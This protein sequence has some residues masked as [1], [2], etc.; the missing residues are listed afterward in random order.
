MTDIT[1][2]CLTDHSNYSNKKLRTCSLRVLMYEFKANIFKSPLLGTDVS[3]FV[4]VF[5]SCSSVGVCVTICHV[6]SMDGFLEK[7][8][9]K[10]LLK[11]LKDTTS[12]A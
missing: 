5:S 11:H 9:L 8:C 12:M 10:F 2:F 4:I 7:I 3:L 6:I 1:M